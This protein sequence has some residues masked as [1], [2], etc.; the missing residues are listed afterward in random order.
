MIMIAKT[1]GDDAGRAV[2]VSQLERLFNG[3]AALSALTW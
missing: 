1:N 3:R 2:K